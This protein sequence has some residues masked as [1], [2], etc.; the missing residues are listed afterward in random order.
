MAAYLIKF[1]FGVVI[2]L[3][4]TQ[5]FVRLAVKLSEIFRISPLV[6]GMLVVS[7][8]TTLPELS[9]TI[10][11][12]RTG[13]IG[14]AT[15]T[16]V[17]ST[18]VNFILVLPA[19]IL[20]GKDIR[21][22]TTKTQKNSFIL[23]I[24]TILFIIL[25]NL[26]IPPI[27]SGT[28]LLLGLIGSNYLEYRWGT[29]GRLQ[30]D[31]TVIDLFVKKKV[32]PDLIIGLLFS[33]ISVT[34]GGLLVVN[35]MENLAAI[36]GYSTTILGLTLAGIATSLPDIFTAV[37]SQKKD[38]DKLTIGHIT[39]G[40][41]YNLLLIGGITNVLGSDMYLGGIE[42][43]FLLS[44]VI[45]FCVII[46][47]YKSKNIPKWVGLILFLLFFI[48]IYAVSFTSRGV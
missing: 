33:V 18:I 31:K 19:A 29:L 48:Y 9:V 30:E 32:T 1:F 17:G 42:I 16:I 46:R 44:L 37:S 38:E 27:I 36:S 41:L 28:I 10:T 3:L 11:S 5:I 35:S 40:S 8:G 14:L 25:Q 21:I 24:A 15:G 26:S 34:L 2:L 7:F 12:S 39:G 22:G 23:L 13:N 45:I 4:S 47:F 6:I 20:L 43:I